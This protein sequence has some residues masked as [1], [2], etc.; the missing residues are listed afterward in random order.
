MLCNVTPTASTARKLKESILVFLEEKSHSEGSALEGKNLLL[1]EQI[2]K[3]FAPT[4][5][6]SFL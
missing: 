5:A 1:L 3:F 4:G 2:R 6:N